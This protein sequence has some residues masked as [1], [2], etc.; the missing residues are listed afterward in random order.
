MADEAPWVYLTATAGASE[1]VLRHTTYEY[2]TLPGVFRPVPRPRGERP[3]PH[4]QPH[5]HAARMRRLRPKAVAEWIGMIGPGLARFVE[6]WP[7]DRD[8]EVL[9]RAQQA[10]SE[11]G[12]RYLFDADAGILFHAGA[13][14]FEARERMKRSFPLP[15]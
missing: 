9:P 6:D 10:L 5:A 14:L 7:T 8:V 1:T 13:Q 12:A 2:S 4:E 11:V 15:G 3:G